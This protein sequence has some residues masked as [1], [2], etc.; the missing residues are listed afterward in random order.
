MNKRPV[1]NRSPP[2]IYEKQIHIVPWEKNRIIYMVYS[3]VDVLSTNLTLF[4]I[5]LWFKLLTDPHKF[6][7]NLAKQLQPRS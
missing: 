1:S 4:A 6:F 7:V 3:C 5:I 2:L